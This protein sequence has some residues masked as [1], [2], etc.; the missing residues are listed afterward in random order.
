[1]S[2]FA[3]SLYRFVSEAL[4]DETIA[5][6]ESEKYLTNGKEHWKV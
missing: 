6:I 1:M 2:K 3:L 4:Y 5:S